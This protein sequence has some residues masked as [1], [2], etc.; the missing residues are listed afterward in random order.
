MEKTTQYFK[1]AIGEILLVVIGIL[2]ALQINNWNEAAKENRILNNYLVKI[3]SHTKED[4]R[5]LDT[6]TKGRKQ[7][8]D[9]CKKARMAMLTKTEEEHIYV[10]MASGTAFADFFFKPKTVGYESF[11]NSASFVKINNTELDS[12]LI[13]YHSIIENI[14][15]N[16]KSYNDYILTQEAHISKE[17]DRGL[18]LASAFMSRDSL[19]KLAIP[20]STFIKAFKDYSSLTAFRNVVNLAAF[21]FDMMVNQYEQL[22]ETGRNVIKE[23]DALTEKGR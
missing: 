3:K 21:Q 20:D 23:I 5:Q 17:F 7:I 13:Q 12:L 2:I 10:M 6:I 15:E 14:A 22:N 16:E 8:A 19:V 4:L 1:Y 9:L 11:K 18:I